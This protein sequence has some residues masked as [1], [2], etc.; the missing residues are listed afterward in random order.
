MLAHRAR[1]LADRLAPVLRTAKTLKLCT[2][3]RWSVG[4]CER[5]RWRNVARIV[6]RLLARIVARA[7]AV[8]GARAH[9]A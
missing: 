3:A 4:E 9:Y 1:A 6:S 7:L 5:Q 8:M 2:L